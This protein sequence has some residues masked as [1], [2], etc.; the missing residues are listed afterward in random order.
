MALMPTLKKKPLAD[1]NKAVVPGTKPAAPAPIAPA[2][3][4]VAVA[5][6]P[7]T[8]AGS[9][10]YKNKETDVAKIAAGITGQDSLLMRQA[11]TEG[12]KTANRRGLLASSIAAGAAQG[13][14]V[15]R[16]GQMAQAT[17]GFN[18]A[19]NVAT[20]DRLSRENINLTQ[21]E[22]TEGIAAANRAL[23]QKLQATQISAAEKQQ[24]RD[25]ASK[26]GMAAAD[27]ALRQRLQTQ[28]LGAAQR[29]QTQQLGAESK[30]R[31][32]D[33]NLQ[34]ELAKWNLDSS[35]REKAAGMLTSF[36]QLYE[37]QLASINSNKDLNAEQRTT[38]IKAL[39]NRR[40]AYTSAVRSL[41]DVDISFGAKPAANPAA[42]PAALPGAKPAVKPVAKPAAS[43][44]QRPAVGDTVKLSNGKTIVYKSVNGKPM[45]TYV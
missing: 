9:P 1:V 39:N 21:I 30:E 36:S 17:A 40:S 27:N 37:Q 15:E 26:E 11:R 10:I 14:V 29:L 43:A 13:A 18:A 3:K 24:L 20:A 4:P 12:L 2:P 35:D 33:R 34:S 16:A 19:E 5:P 22:S 45:W 41:Y 44:P 31:K 25:I 23:E 32:L 42:K 38:Q 6:K 28:Q 7:A 8:A